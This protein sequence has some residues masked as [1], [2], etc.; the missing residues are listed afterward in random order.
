MESWKQAWTVVP[1]F[2]IADIAA[3]PNGFRHPQ[4]VSL[5]DL[6]LDLKR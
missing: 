3:N 4:W 5:H 2:V 6:E 1:A